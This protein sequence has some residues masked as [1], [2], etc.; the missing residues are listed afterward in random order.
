MGRKEWEKNEWG[1]GG[2]GW[3]GVRKLGHFTLG[4]KLLYRGCWVP[5]LHFQ[6]IEMLQ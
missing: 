1:K 5:K 2:K 4:P 6:E 3:V